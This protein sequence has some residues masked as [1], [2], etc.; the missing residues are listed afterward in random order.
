MISVYRQTGEWPAEFDSVTLPGSCEFVWMSFLAM[1]K[2]RPT[3]GFGPNPLLFSEI[4]SW[5]RMNGVQFS[6]WE[7]EALDDL[8]SVALNSAA[9]GQSNV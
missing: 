2:K 3:N 5:Q 9:K 4:D 1:N 8:D 6:E 7:L